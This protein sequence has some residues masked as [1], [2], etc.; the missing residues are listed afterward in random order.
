MENRYSNPIQHLQIDRDP[1]K[2]SVIGI[3]EVIHVVLPSMEASEVFRVFLCTGPDRRSSRPVAETLHLR[4]G[5]WSV[6]VLGVP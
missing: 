4:Q 3:S 1:I 2:V 5:D 6:S